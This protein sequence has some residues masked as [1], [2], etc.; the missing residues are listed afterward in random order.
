MGLGISMSGNTVDGKCLPW[1]VFWRILKHSHFFMNFWLDSLFEPANQTVVEIIFSSMICWRTVLENIQNKSS[2]NEKHS[3]LVRYFFAFILAVCTNSCLA[4]SKMFLTAMTSVSSGGSK[5]YG[6]LGWRGNL[7]GFCY[8]L[9]IYDSNWL[10]LCNKN[11]EIKQ[12]WDMILLKIETKLCVLTLW[13]FG[14][15]SRVFSW[16]LRKW[17]LYLCLRDTL[18]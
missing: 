17:H 5:G 3:S 16:L 12:R 15:Q 13:F 7:Q 14:F 1:P 10:I 11:K 6:M 9:K 2:S 8:K 4:L 18:S